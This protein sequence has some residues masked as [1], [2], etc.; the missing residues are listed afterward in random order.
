[1][2]RRSKAPFLFAAAVLIGLMALSA[3][4]KLPEVTT[5]RPPI[6]V[7]SA[8]KA[9]TTSESASSSAGDIPVTRPTPPTETPI[10]TQPQISSSPLPTG[11]AATAAASGV[12]QLKDVFFE[13]DKALI[14]AEQKAALNENARWLQANSA[15]RITVEGHCD[16]RGTAEYNLGLGDRRA[17]AVRDFLLISGVAANRITT[18]S[19]GKERPF[20]LGH[21]ENAWKQNRRAHFAVQ[22]R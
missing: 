7:P 1:M 10:G 22:A 11:G 18:I 20:V 15:V 14:E 13:Y 4:A 12:A 21:D 6:T 8:P 19:Y 16:E 2:R 5:S 3:C 9:P 17:K